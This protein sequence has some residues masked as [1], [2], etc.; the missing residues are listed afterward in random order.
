MTI[1]GIE[2]PQVAFGT[3]QLSGEDCFN[4]T[5]Y[6]LKAG[7]R[8][9][10]TALAYQ[11]EDVIGK[12][13]KK[14]GIKR[15]ELFITTKIP[16]DIKTYEGAKKAI[17]T[18]LKNLDTPYL[19]MCLIH[20]P[21]PWSD[22]GGNYE[23]GNIESWKAMIELYNEGKIKAIGVSNFYPDRLA[24]ICLFERKVIP[25]VNQIETNPINARF[26]DQEVAEKYGVHI[27]KTDNCDIISRRR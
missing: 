21:W 6:A 24:D 11:N 16:A 26:K 23:K 27:K 7:Y 18:S 2:V 5:I 12:A 1:K 25:A 9:I 4:G 20:A 10:D 15:E 3:W 13:I 14:Y 8:H 17:N 19:D 22:Q